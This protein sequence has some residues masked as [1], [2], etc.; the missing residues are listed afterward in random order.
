MVVSEVKKTPTHRTREEAIA[1]ND[2][3]DWYGNDKADYFAKHALAG[4]GEDALDYKVAR[5]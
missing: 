3:D 5:K 4:T 2:E 1:Q